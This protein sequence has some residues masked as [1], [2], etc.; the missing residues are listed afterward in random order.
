[1]EDLAHCERWPKVLSLAHLQINLERVSSE[2]QAA[3]AT[4]LTLVRTAALVDLMNVM[5]SLRADLGGRMLAGL[6]TIHARLTLSRACKAW[7]LGFVGLRTEP[8]VGF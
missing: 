8:L 1:M 4:R 3:E 2:A 6:P 5:Y 7:R